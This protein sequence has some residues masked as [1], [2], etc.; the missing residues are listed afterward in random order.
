MLLSELVFGSLA[1]TALV[2]SLGARSALHS[3]AQ[4]LVVRRTS[5]TWNEVIF[6]I[7]QSSA[8]FLISL[9][10]SEKQRPS[11]RLP[12]GATR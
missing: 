5:K 12:A 8:L 1:L 9:R 6:L 11:L 4:R 3:T 7:A 2:P 10:S